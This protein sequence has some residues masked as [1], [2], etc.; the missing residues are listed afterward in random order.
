MFVAIRWVSYIY[1][2][3]PMCYVY[4]EVRMTGLQQGVF[5]DLLL[6]FLV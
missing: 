5:H 6:N 2:L 1:Y 4:I 3:S